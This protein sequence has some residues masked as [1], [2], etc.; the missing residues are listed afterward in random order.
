MQFRTKILLCSSFLLCI[1]FLIRVD[2]HVYM[3]GWIDFNR[4][5]KLTFYNIT[6]EDVKDNWIILMTVN[7]GYFD[8]FQNWLHFYQKL[9]L[10]YPLIVVAEDRI[11]FYKLKQLNASLFTKIQRGLNDSRGAAVKYGS[12]GFDELTSLRPTYILQYLKK[13]INV[14]YADTD[15][16]WLLDPFPFFTGNYDIWMQVDSL[17]DNM[18]TGLIAIKS[19]NSTVNFTKTWESSLQRHLEFDQTAFNNVFKNSSVHLKQLDRN[20]FPSGKMYFEQFNKS[21][22]DNVVIVHNNYIIGHEAKLKRFVN[23]KLWFSN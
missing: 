13:G 4:E 17:P 8:F 22:H 10:K 12:K 7:D 11:V 23:Y 3:D 19:N 20:R 16:V 9:N 18:C 1:V 15:S 5:N 6:A 2:T 14:L 21:Q